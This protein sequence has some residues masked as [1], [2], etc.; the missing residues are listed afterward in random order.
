MPQRFVKLSWLLPEDGGSWEPELQHSQECCLKRRHYSGTSHTSNDPRPPQGCSLWSLSSLPFTD[1]LQPGPAATSL[2]GNL[3]Q[4]LRNA[5]GT[6]VPAAL[7][8]SKHLHPRQVL[9]HAVP[10][11]TPPCPQQPGRPGPE[12]DLLYISRL[13][14]NCDLRTEMN[15]LWPGPGPTTPL[16][17][18]PQL[19]DFL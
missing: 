4:L 15:Q 8:V 7:G 18:F 13:E 1:K 9:S 6:E 19:Q 14:G 16:G 12:G 5:P 3:V 11:S 10:S 17:P 2:H